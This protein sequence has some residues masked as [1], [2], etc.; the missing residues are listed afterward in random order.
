VPFGSWTGLAVLVCQARAFTVRAAVNGLLI[1][2]TFTE[3]V[4]EVTAAPDQVLDPD[5]EVTVTWPVFESVNFQFETVAP[6]G[7]EFIV[8]VTVLP[9][10]TELWWPEVVPHVRLVTLPGALAAGAPVG[11]IGVPPEQT[12]PVVTI[13]VGNVA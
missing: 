8:H 13:S 4:P 6:L 5:D 12:C 1:P 3:T 2:E 10:V 7:S 11:Q 9:L